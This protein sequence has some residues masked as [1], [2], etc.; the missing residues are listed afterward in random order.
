ME[1]CLGEPPRRFLLYLHFLV[2]VFHFIFDLHFVVIC[3]FF[4]FTFCF[5][6]SSLTLPWTITGVFTLH[7]ILSAQTNATVF[8]G[9][10]LPI[11]VFLPYALLPTLTQPAFIKVSLGAGSSSLNFAG[12]HTDPQNTDLAHLFA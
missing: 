3:Q 9:S 11:G 2:D 12:I 6:T 8:S 4:S 1:L 10:F 7:F 5:L